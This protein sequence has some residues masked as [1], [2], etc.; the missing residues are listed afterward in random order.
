MIITSAASIISMGNNEWM[1]CRLAEMLLFTLFSFLGTRLSFFGNWNCQIRKIAWTYWWMDQSLSLNKIDG[2][3]QYMALSKSF[4]LKTI[5]LKFLAFGPCRCKNMDFKTNLLKTKEIL[6]IKFV[7]HQRNF[8]LTHT[9]FIQAQKLCWSIWC[10][11]WVSYN[12]NY[13][14]YLN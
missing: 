4:T 3:R 1:T 9:Y 8:K 10:H 13:S 14:N 6:I 11:I 7:K 2:F 12:K 5:P